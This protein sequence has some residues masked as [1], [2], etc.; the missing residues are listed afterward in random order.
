MTSTLLW[1][2]IAVQ[3]AMGA[4]DTL[5]HHELTER[6]AWRPS[7]KAELRLHAIRNALYAL[8]FLTLGFAEPR[9]WLA[10]LVTSV[11]I[12][13]VV[14]TLA[15]FVEEDLSRRL[16][17]SE[18]VNHTLLALNY[19]G[20][21]VLMLPVLL[22]WASEPTS[23]RFVSHGA[24]SALATAAALG[25]GLFGLR[26]WLAAA[27]SDRLAPDPAAGL[28]EVLPPGRRVL[29][30][31]GTGFVGSRLIESLVGAG[32]AV[33]VLT[34]EC[35]NAAGLPAPL[36][37]VTTLADI[38]NDARFDAVVNLAG[39][40]IGNALWTARKRR[41][42]LRSRLRTT[43]EL[44]RLMTRL[45][46]RPEVLVSG[47]AIGWYG[48]R[49]DSE[50]SEASGPRPCFSHRLCEAWEKQASCAAALG[51]RV[52]AL[53]T[54]LV[55]GSEGGVLA[56]MLTPFEFGLGGKLGTGRQWMSW[57]ARDDLVRLICH[58]IARPNLSGPLNATAPLP[59]RNADFTAALGRA[60]RRPASMRMP[61]ALLR[62]L[63]GGL[64]DELFLSGQRVLPE[65][66]LANGF[67]FRFRD[68]DAALARILG[69][70]RAPAPQPAS[71]VPGRSAPQIFSR[72]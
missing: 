43:R 55:L 48:L 46:R 21:L 2:L 11:L 39:E 42:I 33:T 61:A 50:L 35:A 20:I 56:R 27:R 19:G 31:G 65:K 68:L 7:Q 52:V 22:T 62:R 18:R 71:R 8:L 53:R 24:W 10:I 5:F 66:A 1:W 28:A 4:F 17:A 32:H 72:L 25:V 54:G 38:P 13:E 26:D 58:A 36:S 40:P 64:A 34:R 3:I 47:S 49:D 44:C 70:K 30:T 41:R 37:V 16:P 69:G 29:V 9:G 67:V 12:V 51:V 60:L 15:D 57:I 14:I 23:L 63:G 45:E 59:V 6:L